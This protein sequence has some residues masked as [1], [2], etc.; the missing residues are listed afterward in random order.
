MAVIAL[1]GAACLAAGTAAQQMVP[2]QPTG[3][4]QAM[5]SVS[6]AWALYPLMAKWAEEYQKLRPQVRIDVAVGGAGKGMADALAGLVDIGMVSREIRQEEYDRGAAAV[7]V[8]KDAVFATINTDN[9]MFQEIMERGIKRQSFANLFVSGTA[10]TWGQVAA[11]NS[12]MPVQVYTRSDPCGA[13][14][15][16]ARYLGAR[17]ENLKG[18]AVYG[19]AGLAHAVKTDPG[20]IGYS[21]YDFAYNMKTGF[22]ADGTAVVPIDVNE[23]G[24]VD[25]DEVLLKQSDAINAIQSGKYPAPPARDLFLVTKDKF[26]GAALEFVRWILSDGQRYVNEAGYITMPADALASA[27][28]ALAE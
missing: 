5:I 9:P 14:E 23:N 18:T 28:A 19:A 2:T 6:G 27:A 17:Q 7:P 20:A 25:P 8:A 24:A 10:L 1:L 4:S 22:Y 21:N 15:T 13:A 16:W 3:S 11:G 12:A 26:A